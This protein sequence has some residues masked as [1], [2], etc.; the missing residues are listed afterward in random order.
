MGSSGGLLGQSR[1][2]G[3]GRL[4]ASVVEPLPWSFGVVVEP[5][6]RGRSATK[7]PRF[8][9]SYLCNYLW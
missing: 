4:W 5:E 2:G 9:C 6:K 1:W 8:L 3:G 7:A